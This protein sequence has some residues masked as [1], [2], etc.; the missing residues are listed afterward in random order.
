MGICY[1]KRANKSYHPNEKNVDLIKFLIEV[2][3]NRDE[4]VFDSFMGS[5]STGVACANADR[6]F[7]GIELNKE[8][9]NIACERIYNA[10][11]QL[12]LF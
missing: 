11:R 8:Y 3:T 9:F 12:K 10:T 1:C 7:I 5:G 2:A 4:I 6:K